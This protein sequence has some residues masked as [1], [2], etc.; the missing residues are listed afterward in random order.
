MSSDRFVWFKLMFLLD[1]TSLLLFLNAGQL[2]T[3]EVQQVSVL[4]SFLP[5]ACWQK[6]IVYQGNR[7]ACPALIVLSDMNSPCHVNEELLVHTTQTHS[8]VQQGELQSCLY[9]HVPKPAPAVCPFDSEPVDGAIQNVHVS[10]SDFLCM[11]VFPSGRDRAEDST[12]W[13]WPAGRDHQTSAGG[14]QQ[15]SC[16]LTHPLCLSVFP[17]AAPQQKKWGFTQVKR[18]N[19]SSFTYPLVVPN[20]SKHSL[21]YVILCSAGFIQ[22]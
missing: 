15:H 2:W 13:V 9:S 7:N 10:H 1:L 12:E 17:P 16:T 11:F 22:V 3:E 6:H 14:Y 8:C 18:I 20:L 5:W 19:L 21:K 4:E